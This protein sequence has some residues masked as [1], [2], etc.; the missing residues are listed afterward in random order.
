MT[1]LL[2]LSKNIKKFQHFCWQLNKNVK[3][4]SNRLSKIV[5]IF[6]CIVKKCEGLNS[7]NFWNANSSSDSY[8]KFMNYLLVRIY[9]KILIVEIFKFLHLLHILFYYRINIINLFYW[10]TN[11]KSNIHNEYNIYINEYNM[12][13][14]NMYVDI[15]EPQKILVH[16]LI[17]FM[18]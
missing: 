16:E 15:C 1:R 9:F 3:N 12:Y 14:K 17:I 11:K 10:Q 8:K 2:L 13:M 4:K 5:E 7:N 6:N 18:H